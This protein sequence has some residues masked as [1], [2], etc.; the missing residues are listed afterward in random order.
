MLFRS[1]RFR[2]GFEVGSP[3]LTDDV[4]DLIVDVLAKPSF[5]VGDRAKPSFGVG[6][7]ANPFFK[8]DLNVMLPVLTPGEPALI[9]GDLPN[10][11]LIVG[12]LASELISG[13]RCFFFF[14]TYLPNAGY[15]FW[16]A[17]LGGVDMSLYAFRNRFRGPFVGA[18][19]AA[20]SVRVRPKPAFF[21][22]SLAGDSS[23]DEFLDFFATELLSARFDSD[24]SILEGGFTCIFLSEWYFITGFP[25]ED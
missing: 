3:V 1:D 17:P 4:P 9:V 2:L 24:D 14:V 8:A 15:F 12:D 19:D 20:W 11:T 21:M 7:Y 18:S 16:F 23:F 5:M 22:L 13:E 25:A 6:D 10:P